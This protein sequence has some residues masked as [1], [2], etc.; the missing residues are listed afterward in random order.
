MF[1]PV[2]I[3]QNKSYLLKG[4]TY[5][6]VFINQEKVI[7]SRPFQFIRICPRFSDTEIP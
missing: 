6:F 2:L 1:L 7:R 4:E 5:I 3:L